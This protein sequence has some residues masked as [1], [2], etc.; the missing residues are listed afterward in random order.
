MDEL[1]GS[2]APGMKSLIMKSLMKANYRPAWAA[3]PVAE[4]LSSGFETITRSR[5][6][7]FYPSPE[8]T[9]SS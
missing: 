7:K 6:M 3:V 2:E 1:L 8:P 4:G 9:T 5:P